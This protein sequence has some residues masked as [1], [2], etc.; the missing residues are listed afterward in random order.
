MTPVSIG[1]EIH[2]VSPVNVFGK[3]CGGKISIIQVKN[4]DHIDVSLQESKGGK[5]GMNFTEHLR[6]VTDHLWAR[7]QQHPFINEIGSG[8][9]DLE[10]FRYFMKQDYLFLIEFC[11]V[12]SLAI[13]RCETVPDMAWFSRLL[14]ETLNKEME[15]H[16]SFCGD[17]GIT[18]NEL[19]ET[20]MSPTTYA[21]TRHLL[22]IAYSSGP[23]DIATAILPCSWGYSE[24]GKMLHANGLPEHAPLYSRWI[25]MYSSDEFADL[26]CWLRDF[27][28]RGS[29]F[30]NDSRKQ[31]LAKIFRL[32]S[33]YE[34]QFWD[35]AYR[36]ESW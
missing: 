33:E 16:T 27:I 31:T 25:R 19:M 2:A 5:L 21:Y 18:T 8:D 4:V 17:F 1:P 3:I 35:A 30:Y 24:L 26:A 22:Q 15:L 34:Y 7:E 29:I 9:L 36:M 14:D 10:R 32:S 23:T 20:E 11:K 28:D 12:I 6:E 13:P